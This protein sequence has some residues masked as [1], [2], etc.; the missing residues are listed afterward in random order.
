RGGAGAPRAVHD[1]VVVGP[2]APISGVTVVAGWVAAVWRGAKGRGGGV[3]APAVLLGRL[4]VDGVEADRA[5]VTPTATM[6]IETSA[7]VSTTTTFC[8]FRSR[9]VMSREPLR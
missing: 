1:A 8:P 5:A 7:A 4:L 6:R 3:S 2:R 9:P